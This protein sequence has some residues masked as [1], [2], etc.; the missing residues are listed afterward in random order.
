MTR[1][2]THYTIRGTAF[3]FE[4]PRASVA[5]DSLPGQPYEPLVTALID[6]ALAEPEAS[7]A[8]IGA[9]Y[10]FFSCW[11]AKHA[12]GVPVVGFEPESTYV[13]VFRRN[14]VHNRI[15][16][17]IVEAALSDRTGTVDFHGRTVEPVAGFEPWRRD[18]LR[19][20]RTA[21]R[22]WLRHPDSGEDHI[23]IDS[24]G[25]TPTFSAPRIVW[26][27]LRER[28]RPS[29]S[30]DQRHAVPALTM[31]SWAQEHDFWPTIIKMD[32]HGGEGP[33]LRGMSEVL[34]RTRHVF[35]ELHT[36]DYLVDCTLGE[37][38]E[39]LASTGMD[40]Y[41]VR[42]FRRSSGRLIPLTP[43]RRRRLVN[44]DTWS[45]EDLYFMKFLYATRGGPL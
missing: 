35:L 33:A 9:L 37:V 21:I 42:G 32:V 4:D 34:R 27:T 23:A 15:S 38:V 2:I 13:E 5:R 14:L 20:A 3:A 25:D 24:R 29:G 36:P 18:Y 45:P 28:S 10:G 40:L 19:S 11:V 22:H 12:P 6:A 41:E 30:A 44:I 31:D 43:Q 1:K 39:L 16:V 26:E 8:D 7:F 17:Q